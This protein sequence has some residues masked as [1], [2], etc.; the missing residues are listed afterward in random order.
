MPSILPVLGLPGLGNRQSSTNLIIFRERQWGFLAGGK[1]INGALSRDPGNVPVTVLRPG[2]LMGK[3]TASGLY[4]PSIIGVTAGAYT[5][6]GTSLTVSAAQAA[7]IVRR[8]GATGTGTLRVIGP[9]TAAGTVAVTSMTYSAVNVTTGVITLTSLGVDKVAGSLIS[10]ADGSQLPI[11]VIPDG[12]GVRVADWDGTN[13]TVPF[14]ELPISGVIITAN[15][16]P[17]PA[18][19]SL[20][21]WVE[22]NLSTASGGKFVFDSIF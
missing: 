16:L 21:A 2:T 10:V 18:D 3:I 9:P 8:S 22:T 6:G 20:Q 17:W 15:L 12:Y 13:L 11:T 1:L 5:S 19:A 14:V 7:E 4:A